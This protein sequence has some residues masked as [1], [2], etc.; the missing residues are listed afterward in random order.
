[1]YI[2]ICIYIY[3]DTNITIIQWIQSI[4]CSDKVDN[5]SRMLTALVRELQSTIL[6]EL[7]ILQ[8]KRQKQFVANSD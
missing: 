6:K 3:S 1:M 2:V 5:A 4:Q 8:S 7:Q